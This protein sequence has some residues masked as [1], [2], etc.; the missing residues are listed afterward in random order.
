MIAFIQGSIFSLD[1]S[2]VVVQCQGIGYQVKISLQTYSTLKDKKDVF[3]HTYLQ[4][5]EDAHILYGFAEPEEKQM[6]EWL[7]GVTGIGGGTALTILSGLG[8]TELVDVIANQKLAVL[9]GIKGIGEKTAARILLELKDKVKNTQSQ[10][11]S[12]HANSTVKND[13]LS[14][15]IA[16]GF[17]K[18]EV[19]KKIDDL[20]KLN[21]QCTVE[22]LIR[23]VL[24]SK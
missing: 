1:P 15:L 11:T 19:E 14:A 17:K 3:L 10:Q 5:K 4:I 8:T 23:Q 20:L 7:L 21:P 9:K 18:Q 6:F 24:K 16:L 22:E 12:I 13:T 2:L